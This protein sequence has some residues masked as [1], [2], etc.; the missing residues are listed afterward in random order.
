M[1][2]G[3]SGCRGVL[4]GMVVVIRAT[5]LFFNDDISYRVRNQ[6]KIINWGV[7]RALWCN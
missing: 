4:V 2:F 7:D 1:N 6:G 5:K 3:S